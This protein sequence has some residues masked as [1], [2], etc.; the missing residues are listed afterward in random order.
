MFFPPLQP[1]S[2]VQ[3]CVSGDVSIDPSASIASGV[4][5]QADPECRIVISAGVCIG[6]GSILH[7]HGGDIV[8]E[9]GAILGAGVL[10][11]GQVTIGANACVGSITTLFNAD[12]QPSEAIASGSVLGDRSRQIVLDGRPGVEERRETVAAIAAESEVAQLPPPP[13]EPK[14]SVN[15]SVMQSSIDAAIARNAVANKPFSPAHLNTYVAPV[16]ENSTAA[17]EP[18]PPSPQTNSNSS[19]VYGQEHLN[20][21]RGTLFPHSQAL[22]APLNPP[23][24]QQG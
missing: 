13:E 20:R 16:S 4:L 12:V 14:A 23:P 3:S 17:P 18:A 8:L 15:N 2:T 21:L 11:I 19:V 9:A 22:N 10:A 24:E 7:A 1:V 5:L 6:M